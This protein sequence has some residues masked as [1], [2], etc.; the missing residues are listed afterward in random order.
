MDIEDEFSASEF[1]ESDNE[2][3]ENKETKIN[4]TNSIKVQDDVELDEDEDLDDVELDEDEDLDDDEEL[5]D[6][7]S[8]LDDLDVEN[9][10]ENTIQVKDN[11]K[12]FELSDDDDDDSDD[13]NYLQKLDDSV[14]NNIL[15]TYYPELNHH[16][17]DE[18]NALSTVVRNS[19]GTIIDPL[20]KTLPFITRYEKARII[21]ER[22]K[23]INA[24]ATPMIKTDPS[25]IDGYLIA[26]KEFEEKK[27]PYILKRPLPNGGCEYWK[28]IDLEILV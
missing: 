18:V 8:K 22:A 1:E 20:H 9:I 12:S 2:E 27:I 5:D 7:E 3:L 14:E 28:M 13:E 6:L 19:E 21:G 10:N 24:G 25:V 17:Y 23:Q 15:Q 26:L 4:P 11:I 16:N